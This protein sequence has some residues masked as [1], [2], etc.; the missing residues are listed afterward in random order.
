MEPG[1]SKTVRIPA[2]E[3]YGER[4]EDL[5]I[6][7]ERANLPE[8][9]DPQVGMRLQMGT[10]DGHTFE[11]TVTETQEDKIVLDANHPLAGE[12][13]TFEIELQ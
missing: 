3:A 8:G 10:Q 11:V 1:E 5:F 9:M 13:L 6:H 2:D 12:A 4:R 7:M